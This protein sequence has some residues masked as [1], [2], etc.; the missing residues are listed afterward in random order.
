MKAPALVVLHP[1]AC[2]AYGLDV[3]TSAPAGAWLV[4]PDGT[5]L[6]VLANGTVMLR[7]TPWPWTRPSV[8]AIPTFTR[9]TTEAA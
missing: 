1:L 7:P 4:M 5:E 9:N 3:G 6:H 2:D 8:A